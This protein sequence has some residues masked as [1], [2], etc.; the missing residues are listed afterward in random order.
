M[1][2]KMPPMKR[3]SPK[4]PLRIG[5]SVIGCGTVPVSAKLIVP[6]EGFSRE[7]LLFLKEHFQAFDD[8][9]DRVPFRYLRDPV[10]KSRTIL[11]QIPPRYLVPNW[12]N[13]FSTGLFL[14]EEPIQ[15]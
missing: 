10:G 14:C 15:F 13:Y 11:N 6:G 5:D 2:F 8:I 12:Q 3:Y 4:A 9:A 7:G 1:M